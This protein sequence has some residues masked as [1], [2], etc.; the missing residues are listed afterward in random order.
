M[1]EVKFILNQSLTAD[2]GWF[3]SLGLE[4]GLNDSSP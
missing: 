1:L 2:S 3:S 4:D